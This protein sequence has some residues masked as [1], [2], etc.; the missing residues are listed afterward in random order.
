[1]VRHCAETAS[2]RP[3]LGLRYARAMTTSL[4]APPIRILALLSLLALGPFTSGCGD[5]AE[6]TASPSSSSSAASSGGVTSGAGGSGAAGGASTTSAS[7]SG[8]SGGAGGSGGSW[9][10]VDPLLGIGEVIEVEG[11]YEFT[12]GPV[13]LEALGVFRFTDIPPNRIHEIAGDGTVTIWREGSEGT[14]GLGIAPGGDVVMCEGTARRVTRS[15]AAGAPAVTVVADG[16]LGDRFNS[17]N[18]VIVRSDGTIYF[19]DPTYGLDG[20][21]QEIPFQGVFR[22]TPEGEVTLVADDF[23]QPNGIALSPDEAVLYVTDSEA[24]GLHS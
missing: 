11:E 19:T 22:V 12:E 10:D 7:G 18:D 13:W 4:N 24:G 3:A 16:Y 6:S 21:N 2:S 8:G 14:N 15:P 1:M 17:P 23:E 20:G 9:E 5:D